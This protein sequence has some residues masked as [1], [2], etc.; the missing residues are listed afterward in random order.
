MVSLQAFISLFYSFL[1]CKDEL[2][3]LVKLPIQFCSAFVCLFSK[4]DPV[5]DLA[6]TIWHAL[7][8]LFISRLWRKKDSQ[9]IYNNIDD[10]RMTHTMTHSLWLTLWLTVYD[11]QFMSKLTQFEILKGIKTAQFSFFPSMDSFN[12][13]SF[14]FSS[15]SSLSV[16]VSILVSNIL[17]FPVNLLSL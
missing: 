6:H 1:S 10:A 9:F 4:S 5:V 8:H 14:Y 13:K 7:P 3:G 16:L 15:H 12:L 2:P 17:A 11:S